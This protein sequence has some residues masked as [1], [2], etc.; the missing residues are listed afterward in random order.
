MD[1]YLLLLN[2]RHGL[3]HPLSSYLSEL[4]DLYR[5]KCRCAR[6]SYSCYSMRFNS[7]SISLASNSH[8]QIASRLVAEILQWVLGT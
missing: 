2:H 3:C 4:M 7:P 6:I 5:V 1:M 8:H